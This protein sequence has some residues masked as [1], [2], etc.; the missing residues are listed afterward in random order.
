MLNE[1][2]CEATDWVE[3]VNT[4][5]SSADLS[6]WLLTDDPL[7]GIRPDHRLLFP[8]ATNIPPHDDLVV[9]RG[10][11]GFPF[12]ISC[13]GDT[14]R[15]ADSTGSPID[16]IAV[17]ELTSPTDTWGRYPNGTGSWVQTRRRVARRTSRRRTRSSGRRRCRVDVRT[18]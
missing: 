15:L 7:T 17:P 2:N 10:A 6:G 9:E 13:G 11:S 1:V 5:D 8:A 12:G 18:P 3:L 4:S 14:I 16:E